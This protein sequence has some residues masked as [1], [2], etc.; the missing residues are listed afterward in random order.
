MFYGDLRLTS[1]KLNE[2]YVLLHRVGSALGPPM[3]WVGLGWVQN[4]PSHYGLGWV[5]FWTWRIFL[6]SLFLPSL[7][8]FVG[9]V[10]KIFFL[11]ANHYSIF[12]SN[13]YLD[14]RAKL[15]LSNCLNGV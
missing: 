6:T 4:L 5:W 2:C 9:M 12:S 15:K 11:L 13:R 1:N 14:T 10:K 3:G 8:D 7:N